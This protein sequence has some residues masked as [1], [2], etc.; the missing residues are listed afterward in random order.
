MQANAASTQGQQ[1]ESTEPPESTPLDI[2]ILRQPKSQSIAESQPLSLFVEALSELPLSYQWFKNNEPIQGAVQA[3]LFIDQSTPEDGGVYYVS[4]SNGETEISSLSANIN[5]SSDSGLFSIVRALKGQTISEGDP[6][7]LSVELE[8]QGPF[9]YQWQKNGSLIP[10]AT[11]HF[12]HI[13]ETQKSDTASYRVIISNGIKTIYSNFAEIWITD[14]IE[15]VTILR[16]PQAQLVHE[17][18]TAVLSVSASGGGFITYQWRKNGKPIDNAFSASL[19]LTDLH[20]EDNGYYD[21][22]V[23]NSQGS[24]I[25]NSAYLEIFSSEQIDLITLQPLSQNVVL[26]QAFSLSVGTI[27]DYPLTY[28]WYHNGDIIPGATTETYHVLQTGTQDAGNYSVLVS[29]AYSNQ[30]SMP[31][32]INI[33]KPEMYAIELSWDTPRTREDGSPLNSS[34]ILEYVIEYGYEDNLL[35]NRITVPHDSDNRYILDGVY[36]GQLLLR[37]AT[38]DI[39][40]HQGHF[41]DIVSLR[42]D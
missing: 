39:D 7:Y 3:T 34:E 29:S 17:S 15:P 5:I 36:P 25:S 26:G 32:D 16:H 28:Q 14:R 20:V 6:L 30:H 13:P 24:K 8:G 38:V 2:T 27:S 10:N 11:E 18:S 42:I 21:V 22:V 1:N 31:A 12:Y 4:I 9:Y 23:A 41:S 33:Y 19:T 40:G 35:N 37:I